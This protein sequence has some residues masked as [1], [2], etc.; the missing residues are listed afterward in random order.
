MRALSKEN[1]GLEDALRKLKSLCNNKQCEYDELLARTEREIAVKN[2]MSK[3]YDELMLTN[4]E[5]Q[6]ESSENTEEITR[7]KTEIERYKQKL[8]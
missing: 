1:E 3:N 2:K 6:K 4:K 8:E 7:L 5:L